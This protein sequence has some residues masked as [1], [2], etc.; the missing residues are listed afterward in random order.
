MLTAALVIITKNWKQRKS[1]SI[2]EQIKKQFK[3]KP[4][5]FSD[6]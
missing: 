3:Q 2:G 1:P 5:T 4:N 6:K